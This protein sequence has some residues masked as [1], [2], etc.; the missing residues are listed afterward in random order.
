MLKGLRRGGAGV[1]AYHRRRRH[2]V[3]VSPPS[4]SMQCIN[5]I[6][7]PEN[8][9]GIK[10]NKSTISA[11]KYQEKPRKPMVMPGKSSRMQTSIL[12]ALI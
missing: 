1:G 5:G 8:W 7:R 9:S 12:E 10:S 4:I 2:G 3:P 6:K 11:N